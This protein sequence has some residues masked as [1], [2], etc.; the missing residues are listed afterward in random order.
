MNS[1][2]DN[3]REQA[4]AIREQHEAQ[5]Q[6]RQE[7]AREARYRVQRERAE[8]EAKRNPHRGY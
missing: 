4:R 1:H 5:P 6:P 2:T 3:L 8:T 7:T